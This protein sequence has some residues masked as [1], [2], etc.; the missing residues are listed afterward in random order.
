MSS[1]T[2]GSHD[3]RRVPDSHLGW[4]PGVP[5]SV[6]SRVSGGP[7][8]RRRSVPYLLVGVLLVLACATCFVV[9]S[10]RAGDR[11]PVLALARQVAV[12]QVLTAQD[13]RTVDIAVDTDVAVV[14]A[15]QAGSLIGRPMATSLSAGS[16][17]TPAAITGVSG[18]Q[19]GQAIAALALKAGQFPPEIAAGTHV[20][21]VAPPA[22]T[23]GAAS[24]PSVAPSTWP[25]VVTSVTTP[26]NTQITVV[27]V[28]LD[29]AEARQI[30]AMPAGEL[31]VVMLAPEGNR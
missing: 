9:I 28:T 15:D 22:G 31:S 3:S 29:E 19:P 26:A 10:L 21:V 5:G 27:A 18:P 8:P 23:S 30:A 13:L 2:T 4:V 14:P 25:A 16:L 11:Q 7:H 6:W 1:S 17:V 20:A 12:G 24:Y